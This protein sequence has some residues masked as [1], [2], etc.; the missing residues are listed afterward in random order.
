M[1]KSRKR[2]IPNATEQRLGVNGVTTAHVADVFSNMAARTGFG[3]QSLGEGAEYTLVRLSYNYW[4][5]I[6]LFRNHW[7]SRRIVEVPAQDMV[8]AWPKLTSDIEPK[9]LTRLD[10]AIRKTNT[11]NNVC[12]GLTWGRLFGGAGGLIV[13]KGQENELDQP[14][15]IDSVGLGAYKG[16]LPFDRWAGISPLGDVCTDIER[17]LDFNKPEMYE[18]RVSGGSSFQVHSSRL[19][20]FLGPTVPTPELEAQSYW[21]ISVLEP[22]YES[23][24]RLDNMYFNLLNLS[25][26]ANL[27]GMKFP[28]LAQLLSGL[29]S[30]QE[31]TQ[32]FGERMSAV[33]H[34]MSNQS[35]IPLPK[36]GGI[37]QTQYSFSGMADVLQLFQL[38]LSG[39]AQIPITRLFGRT[40]SGLGQSGDGD[41]RIYE[42]KIATDQATYLAPQLEKLFPVICMSEL[43]EVPDDL[44]LTFPS[45][46]V[47]D[48]KE[49]A[50]LAKSVADTT[51]VYLNGGIMSPRRVAMEVKQSSNL[52]GIGSNLDDEY[53]AGL[54]DDV[55]SE[56]EL[57]E[58]LFGG[59]GA[60]LNEA[61]S[62][63]KA[64][65]EENKKGEEGGGEGGE[66]DKKK[67]DEPKKEAL[68][69]AGEAKDAA[70][71][72]DVMPA[73]L[74]VGEAVLVNGKL[75]V[76]KKITTGTKDL[77]DQPTVQ[78]M[79]AT[80]EVIAYRPD[81]D[82][83]V[84]TGDSDA[85]VEYC[86]K[87]GWRKCAACNGRLHRPE[88]G[89]R[90][91]HDR[92][93]C[94]ERGCP[95]SRFYH[96]LSTREYSVQAKDEDGAS[97]V[98]QRATELMSYHALPVRIESPQGSVRTGV[99]PSGE[100]WRTMMPADYG[101][102]E[103][104]D[105]AD[106]DS[107][108]CYV[109]TSPESNNVYVVDQY[110]LEGDKF[111]EHK[112][113]LGY[114]TLESALEDYHLGHHR[115][116]DVFGGVTEFTVPT[117]RRWTTTHDMSEPC[118]SDF[119]R[120]TDEAKWEESKH[121]RKDDGKFGKGGGSSKPKA[122]PLT[123][124]NTLPKGMEHITKGEH[125]TGTSLAVELLSTGKYSKKEVAQACNAVMGTKFGLGMMKFVE[126]KMKASTPEGKAELAAKKAG[127]AANSTKIAEAA[128]APLEQKKLDAIL[129]QAEK[130]NYKTMYVSAKDSSGKATYFKVGVP[131]GLD[132]SATMT[133]L[134]KKQGYTVVNS[135]PFSPSKPAPAGGYTDFTAPDADIKELK[136]AAYA[137]AK[138]D[139]EEAAASKEAA[140]KANKIVTE[141]EE[142]LSE[143]LQTAIKH[144]TNGSYQLLNRALRAGQ[145]MTA[146][147]ATLAAHLDAAIRKSKIT[148]DTTT[149]R[150]IANPAKFFGE[151]VTVGTVII[152]N[153]F[154]ST[155]KNHSIAESFGSSGLVAKIKL[156]KG[157][158]AL[159]ATPMSLHSS[160]KEVLLPRGSMFKITGVSGK[161][162]EIEYVSGQ[163]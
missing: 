150:G 76:I 61:G 75:L 6:T 156:P 32:K 64:I 43:G 134:M 106:G 93:C 17:P 22:T 145:P 162:V 124:K 38:D 50:E 72:Y 146:A 109:G 2:R 140:A 20:R 70:P 83:K 139:A 127:I 91:H 142:G 132:N 5:L 133:T 107:L 115:A 14:L 23:I 152:D 118:S 65:K 60:G 84:R 31:A 26:R 67:Q 128:K 159:D 163:S 57:G 85:P 44:D 24:T 74:K 7:I 10:R 29:G 73:D 59:E 108:D 4:Q 30:S 96:G 41:E 53:I 21:G 147:Q 51:T 46:R 33:N 99:T 138:K 129:T 135:G 143:D 11:K 63:A 94:K 123:Q 126:D 122:I 110:D 68:A 151:N 92:D 36:D 34:L 12:T 88:C 100:S 27:I 9:D 37:E 54:S 111:D 121:P 19:L 66:A 8:K 35:L 158:S 104:F 136:D 155:S 49:K 144:Y 15:D 101:F 154:V 114:H 80:G 120:A 113:F 117:F 42:E 13:I 148:Q 98:T 48:E 77:F 28:E 112:V 69:K 3:T 141:T 153:G 102:L 55:Q 97:S 149:Y 161:T 39:A 45:I 1:I 103:G 52:T 87:P 119:G 157:S 160:E 58:G 89:V 86:G 40:Y 16:I 71:A 116:K 25:F 82:V 131:D 18:V 78:V 130:S 81:S 105:G 125:K 79:F 47:L 90:L 56:G 62:P 95:V 137:K